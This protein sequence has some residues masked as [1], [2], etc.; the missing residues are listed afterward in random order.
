M[1][2]SISSPFPHCGIFHPNSVAVAAT[3]PSSG[4]NLPQI[5]THILQKAFFKHALEPGPVK[6]TEPAG[7][8]A[9]KNKVS[10]S[11]RPILKG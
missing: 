6:R 2:C 8:T 5:V 9:S 1:D 7:H 10:Q 11:S 4:R 3:A